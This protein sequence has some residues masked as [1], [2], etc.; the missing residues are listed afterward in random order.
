M[1]K[2]KIL[3]NVA[4][5]IAC[6]AVITMNVLANGVTAPEVININRD[7]SAVSLRSARAI[8]N[9]D[10]AI[11]TRAFDWNPRLRQL[12]AADVGKTLQLDLFDGR[13]YTATVHKVATDCN[14]VLGI[15]AKL[16]DYNFAYCLIA[17]SD[18]GISIQA[19][20]PELD[21]HYRAF[22]R[23][24]E[25]LLSRFSLSEEQKKEKPHIAMPTTANN[26]TPSLS[27]APVQTRADNID[28]PVVID[29][30]IVYTTEAKEYMEQYYTG[31]DN[32]SNISFQY[33]NMV[34]EN[35]QTNLILNM[36]YKYETNYRERDIFTDL[37]A[38]I[39]PNDGNMDEIH[40]L[41]KQYR[42]DLVQMIIA[43]SHNAVAGGLGVL[44]TS[45]DAFYNYGYCAQGFS[46][47]ER[48]VNYHEI[49]HNLGCGHSW[50]AN[51][52]P[53]P[54]LFSYSSGY[55][56]QDKNGI[57]RCTVM[58]Y[59]AG[60]YYADGQ[61]SAAIPYYSNPDII[62][63]DVPIG[64][65]VKANNALTIKR[66]KHTISRYSEYLTGTTDVAE[67]VV[68]SSG[69]LTKYNGNGGNVQIPLNLGITSIGQGAFE[70]KTALTGITI[71]TA[72]TSIG[73]EAFKGC[74]GL[75]SVIIPASI[76]SISDNTFSGCSGLTTVE[77]PQSII[78]IGTGVFSGCNKLNRLKTHW[79]TPPASVAASTFTG[80]N[81]AT[82][83]LIVPYKRLQ[84]Y[85]ESSLGQA[86][87]II[88]EVNAASDFIVDNGVLT[89]FAGTDTM[90]VIPSD[91]GVTTIGAD[92]FATN[93]DVM[94]TIA[95]PA[96]VKSITGFPFG[97]C[98]NLNNIFVDSDNTAY[99]DIDG[100]LY[101]AAK[102]SLYVFPSGRTGN[103]SI[104]DGTTTVQPGSFYYS[105][106]SSVMFPASVTYIFPNMFSGNSSGHSP[107]MTSLKVDSHNTTYCDIDGVLFNAAKTTLVLYP[108]SREG[109]YTV[110]DGIT[111]IGQYAFH[112]N[113][114]LS[115]VSL[116]LSLQRIEGWAFCYCNL[117]KTIE[118]PANVNYIAFMA[119]SSCRD[120][121]S[122]KSLNP[123]PPEADNTAFE[124]VS[125]QATLYVKT[126]SKAAYKAAT[127]WKNF[128]NIVEDASLGVE[129][130]GD[131]LSVWSSGGV[132]HLRLP[133]PE[134]VQIYSIT[135]A[136]VKT[137]SAPAGESSFTLPGGLYIIKTKS[138]TVRSIVK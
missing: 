136:L 66:T 42:A 52:E 100:V 133:A 115:S 107:N 97:E 58:S 13:L 132:L 28:E 12:T 64:D 6:L 81:F 21:E 119:F 34:L 122:V 23:G 1:K 44:P 92:A 135:G 10:D 86:F 56:G 41:R 62:V 45:E 39:S 128:G 67:F 68:N 105:K 117:L 20:I 103:F 127:E 40:N 90:V 106:L 112:A 7:A 37:E 120:L 98:Y 96:S 16:P 35:S 109:A 89:K 59:S 138:Q 75:I 125:S 14:G 65:P 22:V 70:N 95:I 130:V 111:T 82:C 85:K 50:Q 36:V 47:I 137:V 25:T 32:Q 11:E 51:F 60:Q 104:P 101:D 108:R 57:W 126:G 72:V 27:N 69:V 83:N 134:T 5:V 110:P 131:A 63:N 77:I 24:G 31:I 118:L 61:V 4:I 15:T 54:G 87:S 48:I 76:T 53:G 33:G 43:N 26:T 116:P 19:D 2:V 9:P 114:R 113:E 129:A 29:V 38:L 55:R 93:H 88:S 99:S 73:K 8:A 84:Q 102:T 124:Y 80:L 49:G 18:A 3:R 71:P 91:R 79:D 94:L 30:M 46:I 17:I 123:T 74:T 78:S 121:T